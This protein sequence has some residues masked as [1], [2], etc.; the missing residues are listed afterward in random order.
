M[1]LFGAIVIWSHFHLILL[2]T[3]HSARRVTSMWPMWLMWLYVTVVMPPLTSS[4]HVILCVTLV[5]WLWIAICLC[6]LS[7]LS[8]SLRDLSLHVILYVKLV[9]WLYVSLCQ[10]RRVFPQ[11]CVSRSSRDS[12]VTQTPCHNICHSC[13]VTLDFTVWRSLPEG[14]PKDAR[15]ITWFHKDFVSQSW[16]ASDSMWLKSQHSPRVYI[17]PTCYLHATFVLPSSYHHAFGRIC[18]WII[19]ELQKSVRIWTW[20]RICPR[21]PLQDKFELCCEGRRQVM[22][23]VRATCLQSSCDSDC[24][25]LCVTVV[26]W[27]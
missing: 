17:L 22:C 8:L 5:K 20:A 7:H 16:C 4:V 6:L 14:C 23:G 1:W 15:R 19:T 11:D 13:N 18:M 3:R 27:I 26:M 2:F 21:E 12:H 25:A 24:I 10:R 9:M